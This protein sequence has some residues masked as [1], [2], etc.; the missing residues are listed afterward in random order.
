MHGKREFMT[1]SFRV[2]MKQSS[3]SISNNIYRDVQKWRYIQNWVTEAVI[4]EKYLREN[5]GIHFP[6]TEFVQI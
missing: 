5:V 4:V 3:T 2:F 1:H 6:H